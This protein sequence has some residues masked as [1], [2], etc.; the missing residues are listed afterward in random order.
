MLVEDV[1][2]PILL[3]MRDLQSG[4]MRLLRLIAGGLDVLDVDD[5]LVPIKL[6][7]PE[8]PLELV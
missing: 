1:P 5:W 8:N 4:L 6:P 7:T 3:P 2:S